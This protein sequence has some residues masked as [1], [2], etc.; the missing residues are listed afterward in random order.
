MDGTPGDDVRFVD[1]EEALRDRKRLQ[2]LLPVIDGN[3][4]A[5]ANRRAAALAAAMQ[6]GLSG[7]PMVDRAME[8]AP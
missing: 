8:I 1:V 4:D 5:T 2:W 6:I 7:L 3:D